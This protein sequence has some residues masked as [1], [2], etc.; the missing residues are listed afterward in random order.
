M[1]RKNFTETIDREL[2]SDA[3]TA[4]DLS[5]R[6]SYPKRRSNVTYRDVDGET[7]ILDRQAT[8]I[9]KLNPTASFI[10]RCCDGTLT[11]EE[12]LDSFVSAYDVDVAIA[13]Q[14]LNQV[15]A[16]L[17]NVSLLE[18]TTTQEERNS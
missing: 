3:S 17:R 2:S 5:D 8:R 16:E 15:L 14:D 18:C 4:S 12:I 6:T 11:I 13:Q 9:H 10:W 7:V 1:P